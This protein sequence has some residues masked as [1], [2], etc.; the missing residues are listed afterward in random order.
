MKILHTS[1][2]HLGKSIHGQSLDADQEHAVL[3]IERELSKG[4]K[5]LLIAGDVFD[6]AVP[7]T[8]AMELLSGFLE[9]VS[10]RGT[11][12]IIIP[13]NHDNPERLDF[14]SG[15]IGK[16]GVHLRCK[17]ESCFEPM[18]LEENGEKVQVFAL[19]FVEDAVVRER[20]PD[21]E[22][23][24]HASAVGH[25]ISRMKEAMVPGVPSILVAHE[26]TGRD[27]VSS[28]S[29]RELL[30]GN[31]GRVPTELFSGFSYVALGHLHGPQTASR[32]NNAVYSGSILQ[33][34]FSEH[35]HEKGMVSLTVKDGQVSSDKVRIEPLKKMT[36]IEDSLDNILSDTKYI[37]FSEDYIS[38]S[39]TDTGQLF[40]IQTRLRQRFSNLLEV[41]MPH[42]MKDRA[43]PGSVL[44]AMDSPRE[45][46][47]LFLDRFGWDDPLKRE[48]AMELFEDARARTER[49]FRRGSE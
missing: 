34:S 25:L 22:L 16:Q 5:A 23:P 4:Y 20:F 8:S 13:G 31:H 36:C 10:S 46:F 15:I 1:D 39:L 9:R 29:E 45:L 7:P 11:Q 35:A 40:D 2:W 32:E 44:K 19:P 48:R 42:L 3:A 33:Y 21:A 6:R 26:Y 43:D 30:V 41:K 38:V 28:D 27:V 12:V 47:S 49:S 14:A 18:V 17:Y 24:D 37:L